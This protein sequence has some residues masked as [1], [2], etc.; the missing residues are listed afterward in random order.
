[1]IKPSKI[2]VCGELIGG[3]LATMLALTE[4]HDPARAP[5]SHGIRAAAL[6]NPIVNWTGLFETEVDHA[7]PRIL[8][9]KNVRDQYGS[10]RVAGHQSLTIS[11]LTTK[12]NSLFHKPE[13][14]YDPFASPLLFFRTPSTDLPNEAFPPTKR[15]K[16]DTAVDIPNA[17]PTKKRRSLRK[18][19][20]TGS[21]LLLP[22]IRVEV[23]RDCVLKDQG[24][25]LVDLIRRSSR[26]IGREMTDP[27]IGTP[28]R[29]FELIERDGMGL[30]DENH[31]LEIGRWFGEILR[32]Q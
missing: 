17:E 32:M 28:A 6:C 24:I 7:S 31:V 12:R 18:Y 5:N 29:R 16:A 8:N 25:E 13:A 30:W 4:C 21:D 14:Y 2:G 3:S 27:G 15:S 1:M 10:S 23:G 22:D 9:E 11:G 26:Y 19:P 20:P